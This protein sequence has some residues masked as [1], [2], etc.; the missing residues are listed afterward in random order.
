MLEPPA[1]AK[2]ARRLGWRVAAAAKVV[3]APADEPDMPTLPFVQFCAAIQSS[4]S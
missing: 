1:W 4:V 3:V 2:N